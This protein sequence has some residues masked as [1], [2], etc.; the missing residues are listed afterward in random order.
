ME[1]VIYYADLPEYFI[2]IPEKSMIKGKVSKKSYQLGDLVNVK[3]VRINHETKK[4]IL[5]FVD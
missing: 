5:D 3:I 4:V 1:G 2:H